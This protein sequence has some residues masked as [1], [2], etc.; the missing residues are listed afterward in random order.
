MEY[1]FKHV[2]YPE[3]DLL[4]AMNRP[5]CYMNPSGK[6]K[7]FITPISKSKNIDAA[8]TYALVILARE[9]LH[10]EIGKLGTFD[11]PAGFYVYAGSALK[12]LKSRLKHHLRAEKPLHWHIDYLLK[13]AGIKDVWYSFGK[14]KLEC[15][16]NTITAGLPGAEPSIPGF[17]SSDCHCLT[18]LTYFAK[19]PSFAEFK[20]EILKRVLP[21]PCLADSSNLLSMFG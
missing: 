1:V 21:E 3:I 17:G 15:N 5:S 6:R 13:H 11:F 9:Q 7:T 12:G 10:L 20:A 18:H 4:R 16:W 14:E 19:S 2:S 8:G